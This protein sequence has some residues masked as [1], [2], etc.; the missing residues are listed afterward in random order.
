MAKHDTLNQEQINE[1]LSLY[2][3]GHVQ[4]EVAK[5]TQHSMATVSKYIV[6]AG[7]GPGAGGN[8]S[9]QRKVTDAE[10]LEDIADGLTRLEIAEKRGVHPETLS[11]RMHNLGVYANKV[12]RTGISVFS[13]ANKHTN[14]TGVIEWRWTA[15]SAEMVERSQ[16][17][18]YELVGILGRR[19]KLR[20]KKC[21]TVVERNRATVRQKNVACDGCRKNEEL[22]NYRQRLI[23]VLK[24]MLIK[25]TPRTCLGCGKTFY[26]EKASQKY[27]TQKCKAKS[28]SRAGS[29]R[30]RCRKYGVIYNTGIS[31]NQVF[32][33]DGGIC[34]I[35]GGP[36]CKDDNSWN[37]IIGPL[38]P[39]ID[40]KIALANGGG[41]TWD[42]VQLA[43]AICNSYK[44]D[45]EVS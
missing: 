25:R 7:L 32:L 38:Y 45:L 22:Q 33:R 24:S 14:K 15:R 5:M 20:C 34:Q 42:N 29:I 19:M 43:H 37:G 41:H 39:T 40:H 2:K 28:K 17:G 11:R 18:K 30:E 4:A 8:Q 9:T 13:H 31:L 36:C 23:G 26:S 27:C 10:I 16:S 3:A 35:C 6:A 21:G 44:R 1:I 12:S